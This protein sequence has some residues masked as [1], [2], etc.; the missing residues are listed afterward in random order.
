ME[1][2]SSILEEQSPYPRNRLIK[3]TTTLDTVIQTVCKWDKVDFLKLDVQGFE[4]EV[5]NGSSNCL[6][7][8]ELV[9]LEASLIP[10]N[11][12]CPL[13]IDVMSFMQE[14]DFQLLDFCSQIRRKDGALW[15]T[16]L[17]FIKKH[18]AFLPKNELNSDNWK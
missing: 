17:M 18:S 14:R 11:K 4:L 13:I 6:K 5:L 3:T 10:V 1:T 2:G 9:L 15:Q 7:N 8:C 12:N 16:D